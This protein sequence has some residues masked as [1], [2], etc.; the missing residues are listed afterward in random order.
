MAFT[1][2]SQIVK[3]AEYVDPISKEILMRG[4]MY[5]Q[6]N[7]EQ[8][9]KDMYEAKSLLENLPSLPGEDTRVKN[10]IVS[11]VMNQASQITTSDLKDPNVA[12]QF[13]NYISKVTKNP[14]ILGIVERATKYNNDIK[15]YKE[16]QAKGKNISPWNMGSIQQAQNYMNQGKYIRDT[17]FT[18]EIQEDPNIKEFKNTI[19]DNL[20]DQS[21]EVYNPKT[22]KIETT[23]GVS[24]DRI[25]G[26]LLAGIKSDGYVNSYYNNQFNYLTKDFDWN[27]A[28]QKDLNEQLQ[29]QQFVLTSPTA[30]KEAKQQAQSFISSYNTL[31]NNQT[32]IETFKR[33]QRD[34]WLKEQVDSDATAYEHL[35]KKQEYDD[36]FKYTRQKEIDASFKIMEEK[37]KR[38]NA[39]RADLEIG[40]LSKED[41]VVYNKAAKLG[42]P[43]KDFEGNRLPI[44]IIMNDPKY[45]EGKGDENKVYLKTASGEYTTESKEEF[46]KGLDSG[47][48]ETLQKA[49]KS[50]DQYLIDNYG[51]S[52]ILDDSDKAPKVESGKVTFYTARDKRQSI[53]LKEF[54]RLFNIEEPKEVKTIVDFTK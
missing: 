40:E 24:K 15:M 50:A 25:S 23:S 43:Y 36:I 47:E 37:R 30:T 44:D 33:D 3:P 48:P 4:A 46:S 13:K 38:E 29:K 20:K 42:I 53:P 45:Q 28:Y 6:A 12:Y 51:G 27:D 9:M 52:A 16:L 21:V 19:L 39:A 32:G 8:G 7:I 17:R 35:S 31:L 34:K 18:G 10:E 49:L 54:K 41:Q 11:D 22:G 14:D 1:Q 26:A 5:Q 2:Y